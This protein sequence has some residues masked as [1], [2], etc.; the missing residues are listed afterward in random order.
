VF[1]ESVRS[2]AE[3]GEMG[4]SPFTGVLAWLPAHKH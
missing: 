2:F 4:Y 1:L 3:E